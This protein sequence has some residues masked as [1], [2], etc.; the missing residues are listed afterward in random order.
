MS[1]TPTT[2]VSSSLRLV[3]AFALTSLLCAAGA[4]LL[5]AQAV[6][7]SVSV[8][9]PSLNSSIYFNPITGEAVTSQNPESTYLFSI[10]NS[11]GTYAIQTGIAGQQPTSK[12]IYDFTEAQN[13]PAGDSV[14]S[15]DPF[16]GAA[17]LT[18]FLFSS[19][20]LITNFSDQS[21]GYI[22]LSFEDGGETYYGWAS[23]LRQTDSTLVTLTGFGYNATPGEASIVGEAA[24]VPEPATYGAMAAGAAFVMGVLRRRR[25]S[26]LVVQNA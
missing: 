12:I 20:T 18:T 26:R 9:L 24:A 19:S 6:S 25:A 22:G 1:S 15:A 16:W 4:S 10:F 23:L 21:V 7:W 13:L 2:L 3:R 17:N 11:V 8:P 14:S 5:R